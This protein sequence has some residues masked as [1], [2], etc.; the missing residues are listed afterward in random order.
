[1]EENNQDPNSIHPVDVQILETVEDIQN[2]RSQVFFCIRIL[3][4][5]RFMN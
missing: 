3:N 1:M 5:I 4:Y 2:R